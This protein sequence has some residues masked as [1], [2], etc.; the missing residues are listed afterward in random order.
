M[1]NWI[2]WGTVLALFPFLSST[3]QNSVMDTVTLDEAV[4]VAYGQASRY[5]LTGAYAAGRGDRI[6]GDLPLLSF[7]QALQGVFAGLNVS[8]VSSQPG[9]ALNFRIRGTGSMNAS[10]EP[11]FVIDGV[12]VVSGNLAVSSIV[13]DTKA[14]DAMVSV[15]PAD[16]EQITILKDAAASALYGSRAANG[17]I[18]I[19]TKRGR[20]GAT[21]FR[22]KAD[23]GLGNWAVKNKET[24][25]GEKQHELTYEAFYNEAILYNHQSEEVAAAYAGEKA[26]FYAPLQEHYTDWEKELFRNH[27]F[28]QN[29]QFSAAGGKGRNT[30]YASLAYTKEEGLAYNSGLEGFTGRLNL[31]RPLTDR[32]DLRVNAALS[33]HHSSVIPETANN[34]NPWYM[35]HYAYKPNFPV[36]NE[37]GSWFEEFPLSGTITN[38]VKERGLD[39][40]TS[41]VLHSSTGMEIACMLL[42]GLRL[43]QKLNYDFWLN[44]SSLYWPSSSS[45][46]KLTDGVMVKIDQQLHNIY[47]STLVDYTCTLADRHHLEVLAGWDVDDRTKKYLQAKGTNYPGDELS[48]LENAAV[49]ALVGSGRSNDRLLSLLGRV[50]YDYSGRYYL[51]ATYRRDGS[52]RLG[53]NCRWGDF[54]SVGM[55]WR[56][57]RERFMTEWEAVDELKLRFSYGVNGTLPPGEY[58]R[59]ELMKY[60]A[61]YT[62]LPGMAPV[63]F[64]SAGLSWEK[65]HSLNA[66]LDVS[67]WNRLALT[68]DY[69]R[70]R[71]RDLL[72]EVP[73]SLTT[74]LREQLRNVGEIQNSGV[75]VDVN[76]TLGSPERLQ[77]QTGLVVSHNRNKILKL[78]G[79]KDIIDGSRIWREGESYYAFWSREWAGVDP[80]TGEEQW[81]LN[82]SVDGVRDKSLTKDGNLAEK[83]IVGKADPRLTGGWRNYLKWKDLELN[84]LFSFSLGGHVMDDLWTYTDSD[85]RIAYT[86][87]GVKQW[88]RWKKPG[89]KTSV[90]RRINNYAYGLHGSSRHL[91]RTDHIRLKSVVLAWTLPGKCLK[92]CGIASVRL[93][94]AGTNLLTW[95]GCRDL[96]PEQAVDGFT[97]FAFPPVKSC[98]FGVEIAI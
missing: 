56:L 10:Q 57:N 49:A 2:T 15:L 12:P 86:T 96:D 1:R 81:V 78:Y 6:L 42:P 98:T 53:V 71:T 31:N 83:V 48:E 34:I 13:N 66:G 11:L 29:Y 26:D 18:L 84:A 46:G 69:Y 80:E 21:R 75:E 22:F 20:T 27:S 44:E 9:S 94:A 60:G 63:S 59:L 88:E 33:K 5:S 39:K 17:V 25:S 89:D 30:F 45:N 7:G 16:I 76:F 38:L 87:I 8:A 36:R 97:T 52:S 14:F 24:L 67:L 37:D 62:A 79:G 40:N 91:I 55:A 92:F 72:Q 95:S 41:D 90:P 82:S 70:R 77:W 68:V 35:L 64:S 54:W 43:R 74:G 61:D 85:G 32:T 51:S 58:G 19:T 3:A 28:R 47:S 50:N 73:V 93:Y 4:V 23:W 65:N